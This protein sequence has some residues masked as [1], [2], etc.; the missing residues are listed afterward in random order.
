MQI[1]YYCIYNCSLFWEQ[2]TQQSVRLAIM[3]S[4]QVSLP[5]Y[6]RNHFSHDRV[7]LDYTYEIPAHSLASVV[8]AD[9]YHSV[10]VSTTILLYTSSSSY[11]QF[12]YIYMKTIYMMYVWPKII[13]DVFFFEN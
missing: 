1:Y 5:V 8:L 11:C 7:I 3:Q 12:F 6:A 2:L 9:I 4:T 13:I 10:H